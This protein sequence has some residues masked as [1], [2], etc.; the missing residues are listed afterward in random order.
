MN[1]EFYPMPLFVS[2]M[3]RDVAQSAR[4]YTDALGFRSVYAMPAPDG[5]QAM[6]HIRLGKHQ[7]LM[8]MADT[9]PEQAP[10]GRGVAI[11]INYEADLDALAERA[12]MFSDDVDGPTPRPWNVRELTVSDPDGYMLVFSQVIDSNRT[13]DDVMGGSGA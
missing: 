12:H 11:R 1:E 7:D 10:K 5:S 4:W 2:L 6:N 8:L 13:F 9:S 3:V